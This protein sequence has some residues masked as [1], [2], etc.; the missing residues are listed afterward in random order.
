L[1]NKFVQ[2][3]FHC[4]FISLGFCTF[5]STAQ[6]LNASTANANKNT[7]FSINTLSSTNNNSSIRLIV[8]YSPGTG[9]DLIA[10]AVSTELSRIKKQAV[11]VENHQGASGNIGATIVAKAQPDGL[12]LMVNAKTFAITPMLYKNVTY[13]PV[14]DFTPITLAAFGTSI[15]VTH[16]KSGF[17][18]LR[19]FLQRARAL[20][21]SLTYSSAGLGTSQHLTMELLK[22]VTKIDVMHVPYKGSSG[23]LND[24][25][26]GQVSVSLVP[27][28]VVMS[29][30]NSGRLVALAVAS[31]KRHIKAPNVATFSELGINGA[32]AD[33]WYGFWGPKGM[34]SSM[35][36]SLNSE[37]KSILTSPQVKDAL[38]KQGLDVNTSTP[39]ELQSVVTKEIQAVGRIIE[40]NKISVN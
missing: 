26:G 27:V 13:D 9:I 22:D 24:L 18:D 19:E 35:V 6:D 11:V 20:P 28:H 10:R 1:N 23:A 32:D 21:G 16:P 40:K 4:V 14:L 17:T 7:N 15:L 37:I 25:L 29:H 36:K 39:D 34:P 5:S 33:I 30:V 8:P 2:V 3:F 31:P 12:T 38:E